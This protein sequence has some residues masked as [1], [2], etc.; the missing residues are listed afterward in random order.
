MR[1]KR[2]DGKTQD[3]R[4]KTVDG[5]TGEEGTLYNWGCG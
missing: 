3:S 1:I 5:L 2:S 4:Q